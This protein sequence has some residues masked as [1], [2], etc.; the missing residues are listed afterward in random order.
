MALVPG[1]CSYA[2]LMIVKLGVWCDYVTEEEYR[3]ELVEAA[4]FADVGDLPE[5]SEDA[6]PCVFPGPGSAAQIQAR[7]NEAVANFARSANFTVREFAEADDGR[8][9][10][11]NE[12]G[13]AIG[14]LPST[15]DPWPHLCLDEIEGDAR[16]LFWM[17]EDDG[18]EDHCED[19]SDRLRAH[20]IRITATELRRLPYEVHLSDRLRTRLPQ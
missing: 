18:A 5:S 3:T 4:R 16:E 17:D 10:V 12:R 9:L 11:L 8:W 15:Q 1:W 13:F 14:A 7:I 2:H 20:G 19:L 6:V